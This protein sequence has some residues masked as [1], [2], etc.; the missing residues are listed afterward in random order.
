MAI[1]IQSPQEVDIKNSGINF[2]L[3][4]PK[5]RLGNKDNAGKYQVVITLGDPKIIIDISYNQFV[6][7]NLLTIA[8]NAFNS[9]SQV[10]T[11]T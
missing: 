9:L 7:G 2:I 5:G 8:H 4:S 11:G 1:N 3:E 6:S 10:K